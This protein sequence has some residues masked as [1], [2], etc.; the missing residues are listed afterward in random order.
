MKNPPGDRWG[1][2]PCRDVRRVPPSPADLPGQS[3]EEVE[4]RELVA[5]LAADFLE[6][7][8]R[9]LRMHHLELAEEFARPGRDAVG[10]GLRLDDR[11]GERGAA[12]AADALQRLVR[13]RQLEP[14]LLRAL[15]GI[16][17]HLAL[18][19]LGQV[20]DVV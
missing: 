1:W 4:R 2:Q 18:G 10:E 14:D 12:G 3:L 5:L 19:Q 8:R 17:R 15:R 7:A 6:E 13:D 16:A 11:I 20:P 9:D